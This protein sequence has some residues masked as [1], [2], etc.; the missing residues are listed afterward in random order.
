[1]LEKVLENLTTEPMLE[2][3]LE[4]LTTEPMLEKVLGPAEGEIPICAAERW[5]YALKMK[6]NRIL[7][8]LTSFVAIIAAFIVCQAAHAES[9]GP[10]A[11]QTN[12][13]ASN[14]LNKLGHREYDR[15]NFIGAA[16]YYSKAI[17]LNPRLTLAYAIRADCYHKIGD[18]ARAISDLNKAIELD[19]S[20]A[21]LL[22]DRAAEKL[23][24]HDNPG[25]LADFDAAIKMGRSSYFL[26]LSR[27]ELRQQKED[28]AGAIADCDTALA[29]CP[30]RTVYWCRVYWCR[31]EAYKAL[32]KL[33]EARHDYSKAIELHPTYLTGY[34][35]RAFLNFKMGNLP[36]GICDFIHSHVND[37]PPLPAALLILLA[38][39][40]VAFTPAVIEVKSC[41]R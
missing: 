18:C 30:S 29:L 1:M 25:A 4:N 10:Y 23:H 19:P 13:A 26:Y 2:K 37:F 15:F 12:I 17:K 35:K 6:S 41:L 21:D 7:A 36:D 16:T 40:I 38:L 27:A 9:D 3:V 28:F 33:S 24:L 14:K 34:E 20:D 22:A 32:G 5:V 31:G 11:G 39:E 8:N